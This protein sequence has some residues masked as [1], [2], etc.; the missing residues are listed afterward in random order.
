MG[1]WAYPGAADVADGRVKLYLNTRGQFV[2]SNKLKMIDVG[3][4]SMPMTAD[5]DKDGDIEIL[6]GSSRGWVSFFDK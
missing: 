2:G 4:Y 5:F 6:V 3:A 1:Y